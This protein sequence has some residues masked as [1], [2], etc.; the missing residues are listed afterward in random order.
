MEDVIGSR[1]GEQG[2]E[3]ADSGD[4]GGEAADGGGAQDPAFEDGPPL[5]LYEGLDFEERGGS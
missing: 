5:G 4:G 1:S 3:A 2:G